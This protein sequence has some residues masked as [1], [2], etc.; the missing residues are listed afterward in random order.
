MV[1]VTIINKLF[2]NRAD[3]LRQK[4]PECN[5]IT[6]EEGCEESTIIWGNIN[7]DKLINHKNLKWMQTHSAGVNHYINEEF[8][9]NTIL[10]NSTGA[11]G[12]AIAEHMLALH[13]SL[14][15][16]LNLYRDNQH[17][18]EWKSQGIVRSVAS[19][20]VLVIGL[21]DIGC[22]YAQKVK[23]LGAHVIGVRRTDLRKPDYVDELYL[24]EEIETLLPR[25]D[26]VAVALPGT[27]KTE[28]IIDADKISLMKN[29]AIIINVGRGNAIDTEALCDALLSDKLYG[30]ALDVTDPEPLPKEHRIWDIPNVIITPHIAGGFHMQEI[31]D[32][33]YNLFI[34]NLENFLQGKPMKNVVDF[35]QGY[36]TIDA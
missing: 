28:K 18:H 22:N 4:F 9:K 25:A 11:Y 17:R 13:L 32:E 8:P 33:I 34:V 7:P 3:E 27:K 2:Y 31:I 24:N 36:R 29:D 1:Q 19:S 30:A 14:T 10:T 12:L 21:G 6:G 15:K 35:E 23:A 20:T 26:V 16:K 5:F